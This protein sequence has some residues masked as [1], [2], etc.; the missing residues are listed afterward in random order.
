MLPITAVES[1]NLA[2]DHT[3]QQLFKPFRIGQWTRLAI[4]GLLAGELGSNG[5]NRSNFRS[6]I[7]PGTVPHPHFPGFP[8]VNPFMLALAVTA[9]VV[10]AFAI[11]I[12][13]M[14]I[15]SMMRFVL[16]DSIIL[17]E[18]HIRWS[19]ARRLG[20]GWG[21]F[22]W[23][24][25]YLFLTLAVLIVLVGIPAAFIL[26]SGWFRDP[27]AHLPVFVLGGIIIFLGL[28][29][30]FVATAFILVLTKDFV[31]PQMALENVSAFEGWRRLWPMLKA[32]KGAYAAYVG[33][34]IVL[35]IGAAIAIGIATVC[36]GLILAVPTVALSLL[37]ILTGKA[38]GLTWNPHTIAL[39]VLVGAVVFA[40]FL[41]LVSLIAVPAIVF[42]PAYSLYFFAGRYPRLS[43]AL[44]A[45][46]PQPQISPTAVP[47]FEPPPLPSTPSPIG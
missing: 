31:I 24:L 4:V 19:W 26:A 44:Y 45:V 8:G 21:Y 42:F 25:F 14:Y 17:K 11:G 27:R 1:I 33:L 7:H 22:V 3:K 29:V 35:A 47:P 12:I 30:F 38:A 15:S 41:Y 39:A 28:L 16:F 34:K 37:A 10:A 40:V 20:P 5:C 36:L 2:V 43:A 23:K 18:C 46:P 13:F 6:P 32:E 9:I